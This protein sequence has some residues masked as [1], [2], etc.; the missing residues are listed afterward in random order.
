MGRIKIPQKNI[1]W[2][3]IVMESLYLALPLLS[4][5]NFLSIAIVLYTSVKT[6][7]LRYL[8]WMTLG[9]WF[10]SIF[11]LTAVATLLTWIFLVPSLWAL[12]GQQM[13]GKETREED[14]R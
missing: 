13:F 4:I 8:P 9:W 6:D 2:L 3:G 11:V 7:L 14:K 12:R 10:F 1:R 5:L